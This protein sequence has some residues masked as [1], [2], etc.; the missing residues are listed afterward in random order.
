MTAVTME[1][2]SKTLIRSSVLSYLENHIFIFSVPLIVF[3]Y[4][5]FLEKYCKP[6]AGIYFQ[7]WTGELLITESLQFTSCKPQQLVI[8]SELR[9]QD[10]SDNWPMSYSFA[11]YVAVA[12]YL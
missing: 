12:Y 3:Y 6:E 2:V 7:K 11:I 9:Y 4:V 10:L 5:V 8:H 1:M